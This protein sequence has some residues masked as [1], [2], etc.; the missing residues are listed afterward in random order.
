MFLKTYCDN[1]ALSSLTLPITLGGGYDYT[2]FQM[3][4]L[5]HRE[6]K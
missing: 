4:K 1:T 2:H 5:W 6:A 3:W